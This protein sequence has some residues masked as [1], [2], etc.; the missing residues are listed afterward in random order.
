MQW[1]RYL[2]SLIFTVALLFSN[3]GLA[4]TMHYCGHS[5]EKVMIG[6]GYDAS[7]EHENETLCC[8][9]D[10]AEKENCCSDKIFKQQ[11]EDIVVQNFTLQF[12]PCILE[13]VVEWHKCPFVDFSIPKQHLFAYE[14]QTHA[15]PLYT[16]YHQLLFYA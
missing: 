6:Y 5:L 10:K 8:K 2:Y 11:K 9:E 13:N 16:L 3:L 12:A 4:V 1:Y 15:P 7:C 14:I